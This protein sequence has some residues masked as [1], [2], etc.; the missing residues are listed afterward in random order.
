MINCTVRTCSLH[1]ISRCSE[2]VRTVHRPCAD[3][4]ANASSAAGLSRHQSKGRAPALVTDKGVLTET[5][6]I[7][8]FVAQS[9]PQARLA[10]LDDPFGFA[11]VQAST[12]IC[13]R[14]CTWP[15]LTACAEIAGPM[16]RP[17]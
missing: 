11:E 13:A 10:P 9:F 6:A 12:A 7:L 15:M 8:A 17:R 14:R 2:Q 3:S 4:F 1:A 5:P 16:I